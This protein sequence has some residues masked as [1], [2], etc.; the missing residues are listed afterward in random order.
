MRT[1]K[2]TKIYSENLKANCIVLPQK[3]R[4]ANNLPLE[5]FGNLLELL[6]RHYDYVILDVPAGFVGIELEPSRAPSLPYFRLNCLRY[7]L[8][9][10]FTS[11]YG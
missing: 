10:Y 7:K 9:F 3:P 2:N 6:R 1:Y 4:L 8:F 11:F 5:F